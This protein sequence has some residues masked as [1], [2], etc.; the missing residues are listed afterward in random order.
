VVDD[1]EAV[2]FT[3]ML[4]TMTGEGT[5]PG[6]RRNPFASYWQKGADGVWRIAQEVNADG[7]EAPAAPAAP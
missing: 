5:P 3:T 4:Y 1:D 7:A 2:T 6:P